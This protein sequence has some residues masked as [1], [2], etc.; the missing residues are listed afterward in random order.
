MRL[1]GRKPAYDLTDPAIELEGNNVDIPLCRSF[2][3]RLSTN[4]PPRVLPLTRSPKSYHRAVTRR[5]AQ[6]GLSVTVFRDRDRDRDR[7]P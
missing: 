3:R 5:G 1:S 6:D 4:W 2:S 7:R